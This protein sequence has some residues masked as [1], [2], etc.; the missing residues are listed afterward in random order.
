M[1]REGFIPSLFYI[2]TY[3]YKNILFEYQE[4]EDCVEIINMQITR[5]STNRVCKIP[6]K[7]NNKPVTSFS[8]YGIYTVSLYIREFTDIIIPSTINKICNIKSPTPLNIYVDSLDYYFKISN[9]LFFGRH[10]KLYINKTL[11][12]TLKLNPSIPCNIK[13]LEI[14]TIDCIDIINLTGIQFMMC[15]IKKLINTDNIYY[16]PEGFSIHTVWEES[17][18][19]ENVTVIHN[20]A[21]ALLEP[22]TLHCPNLV[23]IESNMAYIDPFLY[24]YINT[25]NIISNTNPIIYPQTC[26]INVNDCYTSG[27]Y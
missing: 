3:Q 9:H 21:F 24:T 13:N 5:P 19:F 10:S 12:T 7:I 4:F 1:F 6:S 23:F 15:N 11:I 8:K 20:Y 16:I 2:M 26:K 18:Y 25:V 27:N 14:D 22:I 17:L